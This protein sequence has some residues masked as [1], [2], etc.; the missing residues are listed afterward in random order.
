MKFPNKLLIN[1]ANLMPLSPHY[2]FK[3][4]SRKPLEK[5]E[6][7]AFWPNLR[8]GAEDLMKEKTKE[9]KKK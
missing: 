6:H 3:I 9:Y 8:D 7:D 4:R 1:F 2:S 5:F